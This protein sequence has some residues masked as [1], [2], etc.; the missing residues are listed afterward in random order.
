LNSPHLPPAAAVV[1][2]PLGHS[3]SVTR[4]ESGATLL[5]R[6]PGDQPDIEIEVLVTS[7]GTSLR[8]R[9]LSARSP[10][11]PSISPSAAVPGAVV[12]PVLGTATE[13]QLSIQQYASLRADCVA[14]PEG[15]GE[16]RARYGLDEAG[17]DAETAAWCRRFAQDAAL[18]TTYK[19]LF[20]SFR[21]SAAAAA[22]GASA[23][24]PPPANVMSTAA[25]SRVMSLGEH[26]TMT[27]E[28]LFLSEDEVYARHDL[29]DPGVRAEVLRACEQRLRD[30]GVMETWKKLHALA[31]EKQHK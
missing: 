14:S 30:P 29:A 2:L 20:Q 9:L 3:L 26:A 24:R 18:F 23:S 27:A 28:L 6:A 5:I 13:P 25:L 8:K 4:T 15:L 10:S 11:N 1:E 19:N 12:G 21:H 17:D 31:V 22:S 7:A 16:V